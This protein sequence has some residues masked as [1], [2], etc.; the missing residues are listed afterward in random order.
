MPSRASV[1]WATST[2][3]PA[4]APSQ[5]YHYFQDRQSLIRAVIAHRLHAVLATVEGLDSMEGLRAWRDLVVDTY[6]QQNREGGCP[7]GSLVGELAEP[8]PE[9][10]ADLAEGFDQWEA[11]IRISCLGENLRATNE[12]TTQRRSAIAGAPWRRRRSRFVTRCST[13]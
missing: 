1:V 6:R 3:R 10:R 8:Y 11:A 9:C 5:V 13:D 7:L 4:L 2:T 12:L